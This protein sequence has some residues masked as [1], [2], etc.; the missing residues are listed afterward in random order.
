M[1]HS[2]FCWR[3]FSASDSTGP[4][5]SR[6]RHKAAQASRLPLC[7]FFQQVALLQRVVRKYL[8]PHR[9]LSSAPGR[10][11]LGVLGHRKTMVALPTSRRPARPRLAGTARALDR[12]ATP[13]TG[14]RNH[15]G[16]DRRPSALANPG[17]HRRTPRGKNVF[18][19]PLRPTTLAELAPFILCLILRA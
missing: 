16:Q 9:S 5:K 6:Q 8:G 3:L 1:G 7:S 13:Y 17:R 11:V 2:D 15:H 19:G 10:N 18:L 12:G 4:V 14:R